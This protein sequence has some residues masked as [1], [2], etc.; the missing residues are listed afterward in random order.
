MFV[1]AAQKRKSIDVLLKAWYNY[2]DIYLQA[3]GRN[4]SVLVLYSQ[5]IQANNCCRKKKHISWNNG[6]EKEKGI[7]FLDVCGCVGVG[8]FMNAFV[9]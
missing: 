7:N 5:S 8:V 2:F 4:S 3:V 6:K 1:G 9:C